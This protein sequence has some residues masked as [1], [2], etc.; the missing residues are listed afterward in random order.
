MKDEL[1]SRRNGTFSG[2]SVRP[3][4]YKFSP[5][6]QQGG[7]DDGQSPH[8]FSAADGA[9]IQQQLA[10]GFQE[11]LNRG[12]EQ[13][14]EEGRGK[15]YQEGARLGFDEGL[16]KGHDEGKLA[17]RQLFIDAAAPLHAIT[18]Q[19]NVWLQDYEQRRREEL[20]Q[21]VEK[22]ARQVIRCELTLHPTQLLTLVEEAIGSLPKVPLKLKVLLNLEEYRRISEAEPERAREWGLCGD[23]QLA[24][25]ECRVIT[26]T[27]EMDVGCQHRLEQCVDVLKETLLPEVE[28]E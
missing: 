27:S 6:R 23:A 12:F 1:I 14:L 28:H 19:V 20:L 25:G 22:V 10:E 15:G 11:G 13:G 18:E 26:E 17:G 4:L 3:R 16:R 7:V 8:A 24:P 21:L 9:S 5:L 2:T